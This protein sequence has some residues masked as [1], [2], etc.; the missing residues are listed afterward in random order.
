[1][2]NKY[3]GF[4]IIPIFLTLHSVDA[5]VDKYLNFNYNDIIEILKNYIELYGDL[6]SEE[7]KFF[8][9]SYIDIIE[10]ETLG[11]S[12]DI[13]LATKVYKEFA[14]LMEIDFE[15]FNLENKTLKTINF[16]KNFGN[17]FMIQ[18]FEKFEEAHK[19]TILSSNSISKISSF[20]LKSFE[21]NDFKTSYNW[22]FNKPFVMW[23]ER[24][25]DRRLKLTLELGPI[26]YDDRINII[27]QFENMGMKISNQAKRTESKYTRLFSQTIFI[28][29]WTNSDELYKAM[30]ILYNDKDL[31]NKL[32]K[33]ENLNRKL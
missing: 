2:K 23:F 13:E 9:K 17:T 21:I 24:L 29:N 15:K 3:I 10:E 16:I 12:S 6:I 1:M 18:A 7:V 28:N 11:N 5:S 19:E 26:K 20:I 32:I 22:W 8:V 4:S 25:S 30:T 27:N 14:D 33:I 31:Q